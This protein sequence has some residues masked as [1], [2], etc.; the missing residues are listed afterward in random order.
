MKEAYCYRYPRPAVTT[1]CVVFGF[2]GE[3]LNVLLIQRGNEPFKGA[4]AF[5]GG[6]LNMDETAETGALREL[7]EETGMKGIFVE[8]FHTFS[9][10]ERDPRGRT[11]TIAFY[12]LVDPGEYRVEGNDDAAAAR[13][14]PVDDMPF[15]AFDHRQV[16]EEACRSLALKI[17]MQTRGLE[18]KDDGLAHFEL[19]R[20]FEILPQEY[21]LYLK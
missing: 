13:W 16:F 19:D 6:F 3:K 9:A 14:Y 20:I 18:Q 15:L 1:D 2:D 7:E 17:Y 11:V 21:R 10:V 8:Q 5:P 12:A 4:W